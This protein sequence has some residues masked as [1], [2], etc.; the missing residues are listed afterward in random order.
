VTA[1]RK[2]ISTVE[3]TAKNAIDKAL[4]AELKQRCS[5]EIGA[6]HPYL[7]RIFSPRNLD[8]PK[9]QLL[10]LKALESFHFSDTFS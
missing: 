10:S 1:L 4:R 2:A 8:L 6:L 5:T 9:F 3:P 7:G